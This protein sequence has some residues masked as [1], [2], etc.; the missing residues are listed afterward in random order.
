MVFHV[1]SQ[2]EI[3]LH[4]RM[5]TIVFANDTIDKYDKYKSDMMSRT[6]RLT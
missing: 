1:E 4:K 2:S 3:L 6:P 5:I